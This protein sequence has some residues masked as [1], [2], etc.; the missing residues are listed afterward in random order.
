MRRQ[1]RLLPRLLREVSWPEALHHPWRNAAALLAVMLGVA[2]AFSVHLINQSALSEFGAAVRAVNGVPDFGLRGQRSGFDEGLYER[3]A[4][5]PQVAIASPVI[6]IDTYAIDAQ[7]QRVAL[8][9]VGIDALVA[10]PLA[11]SLM[12]RAGAGADRMALLDPSS[13]FLNAAARE[14][15]KGPNLRVQTPTGTAELQVQGSIAATGAALAVMDIAGVQA[16]F[17]WL[18][19]IGT[20]MCNCAPAPTVPRCCATSRCRRASVP[21][22]PMKRRSASRTSRAPT[23][24]T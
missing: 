9:I 24:S 16:T 19:R 12:P 23:A 4:R 7:G 20:S 10:A 2:L 14:R 17:G 15:L 18:G 1:P 22:H 6:E 3:V 21:R 5:H 13:V 11:P 8:K